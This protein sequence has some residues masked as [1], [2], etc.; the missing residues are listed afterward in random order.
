MFSF[1]H[2][3]DFFDYWPITLQTMPLGF[4]WYF[5]IIYVYLAKAYPQKWVLGTHLETHIA[6]FSHYW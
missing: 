5:L 2:D 6:D 4:P 1:F 3:H